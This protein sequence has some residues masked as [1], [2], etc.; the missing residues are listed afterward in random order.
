MKIQ[1]A[2]VDLKIEERLQK[3]KRFTTKMLKS[4]PKLKI[5]VCEDI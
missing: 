2:D 1:V 5:A 4:T 3:I